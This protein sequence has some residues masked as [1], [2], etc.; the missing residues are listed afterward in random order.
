M[1]TPQYYT[2]FEQLRSAC[3]DLG[4]SVTGER[5]RQLW[6]AGRIGSSGT[7]AAGNPVWTPSY[8]KKIVENRTK[9]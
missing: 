4:Y 5:L 2:S 1:T 8:V 3:A 7:D 9:G 6:K